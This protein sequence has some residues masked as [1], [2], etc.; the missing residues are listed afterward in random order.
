[1]IDELAGAAAQE[2]RGTITS[3]LDAGLLQL[4]AGHRRRRRNL[5]NAAAAAAAAV[6]AAIVLGVGWWGGHSVTRDEPVGPPNPSPTHGLGRTQTCV[7]PVDCLGPAT[8]RFALTRPVTWH[9]PFGYRVSSGHLTSW[10]VQAE[11][12]REQQGGGPY[13]YDAVAGI[14]VL[15]GVRAAS[16]DGRAALSQVADT[17]QALVSWFAAQP[18]L[19]TS[20][21]TRTRIDGR[22]AWHVRVTLAG[23]GGNRPTALCNDT[24]A[25]YPLT[26]T[27]D[28]GVHGIWGSMVADLTAFRLPRAGTTLLWSWAFSHDQAA[29]ARN[30]GAV[31]GVTWPT[32]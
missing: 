30:V 23:L 24:V 20:A 14:T 2:L 15:E 18:Y 28:Q 22:P 4:Y 29:L 31:R 10:M 3:D 17:P 16:S 13:Q 32:G 8:Y 1:M 9:I 5:A 21:I 12:Q 11:A 26:V 7:A 25:C 27:P 19:H 6:V